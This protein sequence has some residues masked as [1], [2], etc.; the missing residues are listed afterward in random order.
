M[1]KKYEKLKD[2]YK[3][4]EQAINKLQKTVADLQETLTQKENE[5]KK[6]K[7][8]PVHVDVTVR[9]DKSIDD[10]EVIKTTSK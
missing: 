7:S 1:K 9:R 10:E 3:Q 4:S 8:T 2:E 5:I 6:I